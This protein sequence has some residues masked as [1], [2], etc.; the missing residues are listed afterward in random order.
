MKN[1][2]KNDE[3]AWA[4]YLITR[5]GLMLF[6]SIL[7][8]SAFNVHPLFARHDAAGEMD[9]ALSSLASFIE[10]VDSTSL[11]GA[12]YYRSDIPQ[13][14]AIGMSTRYVTASADTEA[15]SVTRAQALMTRVYPPNSQWAERAGFLEAVSDRCGGRTGVGDDPLKK[16]DLKRI[17]KLLS[18]V[19][20]ELAEKPY[21]PDTGQP[22]V[23]EKVILNIRTSDGIEKRGFT[24]VYQ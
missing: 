22:L 15:G 17:D 10:N 11:Q 5:A 8:L 19:E 24:I 2:L 6:C 20:N 12:H 21:I 3:G 23:V 16:N 13:D 7:L 9:A 18:E 14:I 1:G 4:D